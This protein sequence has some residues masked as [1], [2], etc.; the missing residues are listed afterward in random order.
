MTSEDELR[1][2]LETLER[3]HAEQMA[4]AN[5]A[6]AEAQDRSYW[7][8]RWGVDLNG[9]MRRPGASELLTAL[10][11]ARLILVRATEA[12]GALAALPDRIAKARQKASRD[13]DRG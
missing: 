8:D 1:Q 9:L 10:R 11:A 5:A 3:E 6:L 13:V 12:L 7:L 4:K 2:R